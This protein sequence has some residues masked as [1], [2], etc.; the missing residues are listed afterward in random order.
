MQD[1]Q[2]RRILLQFSFARGIRNQREQIVNILYQE[3][4]FRILISAK[5]LNGHLK[6]E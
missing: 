2:S 6:Q 4:E 5:T 3:L 1:S